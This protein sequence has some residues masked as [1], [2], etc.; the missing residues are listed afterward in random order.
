MLAV[1]RGG[2]YPALLV[3]SALALL[4]QDCGKLGCERL[5]ALPRLGLGDQ[6]AEVVEVELV[7]AG[8]QDLGVPH[9]RVEPEGD[10]EPA[11]RIGARD[12]GAHQGVALLVP[13]SNDPPPG[14]PLP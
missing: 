12:G 7:E 13:Q 5:N 9:R 2:E 6:Q 4:A 11:I 3:I 1:G 8:A 14:P 10:E